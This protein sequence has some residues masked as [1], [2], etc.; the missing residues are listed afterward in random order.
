MKLAESDP[1]K[2]HNNNNV[3]S[4]YTPSHRLWNMVGYVV[5]LVVHIRRCTSWICLSDFQADQSVI[6]IPDS[7]LVISCTSTYQTLVKRMGTRLTLIN[8]TNL[9]SVVH[10]H[11]LTPT[12]SSKWMLASFSSKNFTRSTWPP[13]AARCRGVLWWREA[14]K[15]ER[16]QSMNV[17]LA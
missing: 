11:S 2:L 16:G 8:S 5:T 13:P 17:Q 10:P 14:N 6:S 4:C 15:I 12:W 1:L 9:Q 3:S 7:I